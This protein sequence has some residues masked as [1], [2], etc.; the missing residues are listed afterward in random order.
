[1]NL[2][3]LTLLTAAAVMVVTGSSQV[4]A[5]P[6]YFQFNGVGANDVVTLNDPSVG[7]NNVSVYAGQDLGTLSPNVSFSPQ[8]QYNTFCVDLNHDVQ[9]NQDYLVDPRSTSD[10][11][12]NGPHIAYLYATFGTATITD[13]DYAAALQLAIWDELANNGQGQASLGATLQYSIP[14]ATVAA[15]LATFLA[16]ANANSANA[17]WLDSNVN[18]AEPPGFVQGQGFLAPLVTMN[19]V[20]EPAGMALMALGAI[21]WTIFARRKRSITRCRAR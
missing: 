7:I 1:V 11:L 3:K 10:G 5:T 14:N 17:Q 18:V 8:T 16:A 12:T 9:N 19:P 21:G 20:P 15:D 2:T 4:F 6:L 13:P